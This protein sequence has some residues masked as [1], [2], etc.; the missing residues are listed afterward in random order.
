ML[1]PKF[2]LASLSSVERQIHGHRPVNMPGPSAEAP[3]GPSAQQPDHAGV[4]L[5][6]KGIKA[7]DACESPMFDRVQ[8]HLD[9]ARAQPADGDAATAM[10]PTSNEWLSPA[11][12]PNNP[13]P[14]DDADKDVV[15]VPPCQTDATLG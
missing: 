11:T 12:Q 9:Q 15:G 14:Q 3:A 1:D 13:Q 2:N 4:M 10:V 6:D 8:Q 7:E 5:P